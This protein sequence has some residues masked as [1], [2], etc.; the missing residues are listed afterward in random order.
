MWAGQLF[1]GVFH[2]DITSAADSGISWSH[3]VFSGISSVC[4][5][6]AEGPGE[7]GR[8]VFVAEEVD[9]VGDKGSGDITMVDAETL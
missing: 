2:L 5:R 3:S 8:G 6:H 4:T 7:C 9:G 1:I